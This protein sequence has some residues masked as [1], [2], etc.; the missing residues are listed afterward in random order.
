M[1]GI[2]DI[3]LAGAPI[4]GGALLGMAAGNFKGPDVQG[5]IVKDMD[6]LARIPE[7]QVQRRAELQRIIDM[8]V[9]DLIAAVHKNRQLRQLAA[10]YEGNWRDIVVFVCAVLFTLVWWNV[11]HGRT[12]WLVMFIVLIVLSILSGVY[13]ARGILRGVRTFLHSRHRAA[14]GQ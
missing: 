4:A 1:P 10:S 2:A 6:L 8:R 3:A 7:D 12:N 11:D 13:A 9:D 5:L 14:H